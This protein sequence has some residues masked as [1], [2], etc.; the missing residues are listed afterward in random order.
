M[1]ENK[2]FSP[3]NPVTLVDHV[4]V[5][6]EFEI[7]NPVV[8]CSMTLIIGML[9]KAYLVLADGDYLF[10]YNFFER[11]KDVCTWCVIRL[12]CCILIHTLFVEFL[13]VDCLLRNDLLLFFHNKLMRHSVSFSI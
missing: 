12:V 11:S 13:R 8:V 9:M 6:L 3:T 2:L 1:V 10:E 7:L 5:L 4:F